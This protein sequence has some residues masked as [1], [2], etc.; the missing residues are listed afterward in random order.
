[1]HGQPCEGNAAIHKLRSTEVLRLSTQIKTQLLVYFGVR[2][3]PP[4]TDTLGLFWNR[5][6]LILWMLNSPGYVLNSCALGQLLMATIFQCLISMFDLFQYCI[7]CTYIFSHVDLDPHLIHQNYTFSGSL[8]TFIQFSGLTEGCWGFRHMSITTAKAKPF[9]ATCWAWT[10]FLVGSSGNGWTD[11]LGK[12]GISWILND[13]ND[14]YSGHPFAKKYP[15]S[16]VQL[17]CISFV[18]LDRQA[19][20]S[21]GVGSELYKKDQMLC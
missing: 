5:A 10:R 3:H 13:L 19:I 21:T 15:C 2:L 8:G 7:V 9:R 20:W 14:L 16:S 1:M 18:S 11:A 6:G 4:A 17:I 12:A